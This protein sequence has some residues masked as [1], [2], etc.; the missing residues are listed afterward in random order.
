MLFKNNQEGFTL[1]ELLV[2]IAI[3]GILAAVVLTSL[4][5]ARQSGINARIQSEMDGIAKRAAIENT[6]NGNYNMVCGSN[7]VPTSTVVMDLIKSIN[8][9][10]S[11]TVTCNS[12]ASE[13][14][15]S[16]ALDTAYWCIDNIGSK[17]EIP[18]ALLPPTDPLDPSTAQLSCP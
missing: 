1:I 17:K 2:V 8:S 16:V 15:A 3:I 7:G 4:N 18:D 11:S 5:D 10:A 13:F 14:A 6:L 12:N 9:F